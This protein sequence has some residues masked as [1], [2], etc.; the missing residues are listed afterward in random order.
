MVLLVV[1][2]GLA[3]IAWM[4]REWFRARAASAHVWH[5]ADNIVWP[6]KYRAYVAT[7]METTLAFFAP[8]MGLALV[9][10]WLAIRLPNEPAMQL[11]TA[12]KARARV[13]A[14]ARL[15]DAVRYNRSVKQAAA[16]GQ[17]NATHSTVALQPTTS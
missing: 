1:L 7:K 5:Y 8:L 14:T 2:Q 4:T 13:A 11:M 6:V 10:A 3:V 9:A 12:T 17:H 15:I 16:E